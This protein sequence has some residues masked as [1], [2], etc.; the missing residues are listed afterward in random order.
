MG[1]KL[2]FARH[3]LIFNIN[4]MKKIQKKSLLYKSDVD[5]VDY[6]VN[7][8]VGCSHGCSFPCYAMLMAKRFGWIKEYQDWIQPC[9][10]EN[11]LDLLDKETPK[12]RERIKFVFLSLATDPF[13]FK[14]KDVEKHSLE[15]ISRLNKDNIKVVTLTKGIYPKELVDKKYSSKNEYGI[16]LVSLDSEFQKKY[17]SG[18]ASIKER[19]KALEYL[20]KKGLKTW[21]SIE[22]YP[23]PNIIDQN[24]SKILKRVKFVDKIVFGSWHYNSQ[25]S[26]YPNAEDFYL[27]CSDILSEFCKKNRIKLHIKS[28]GSKDGRFRNPNIFNCH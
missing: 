1:E 12:L 25:V 18:A 27:D 28:G 19:I 22:P 11:S 13:M 10:V 7:H 4:T 6:C 16:T 8:V 3:K 5:Y 2:F 15:I 21:V 14:Q 23:T 24:L 20:H 17:E 9:L 26:K